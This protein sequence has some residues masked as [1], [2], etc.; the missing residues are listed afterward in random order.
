MR[1]PE[2]VSLSEMSYG[3]SV[4][5]SPSTEI[6]FTA[7]PGGAVAVKYAAPG[8]TPVSWNVPSSPTVPFDKGSPAPIMIGNEGSAADR[9]TRSGVRAPVRGGV[10]SKTTRPV[11]VAP[12]PVTTLTPVRSPPPT[13]IGIDANSGRTPGR[14]WGRTSIRYSPGAT[15]EMLNVPSGVTIPPERSE[16]HTS[17]LQSLAYL[18]CRLLLEKK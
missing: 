18:V 7:H 13:T 1:T 10:P 4:M 9:K 16:E 12:R 11:T 15:P 17:E 3:T 6:A 5:S 2:T 8:T 14:D